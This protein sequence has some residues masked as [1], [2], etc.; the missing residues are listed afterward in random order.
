MPRHSQVTPALHSAGAT[1]LHRSPFDDLEVPVSMEP[2]SAELRERWV[3][4]F[5]MSIRSNI[6][7]TEH[8]LLP[9]FREINPLLI[10]TLL[11]NFN[12]RP[13]ITGAFFVALCRVGEF[14]DLIGRLL[15]RS[16]VCFA[17]RGYCLA[18]ARLNT[19][20]TVDFLREYLRYYLTRK[21]LWFDQA[22]AMSAM[23]YLDAAN[24]TDHASAFDAPW[25]DFV[26]DKPNWNLARSYTNFKNAIQAIDTLYSRCSSA[27]D[28]RDH[29][30]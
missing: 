21:E 6:A 23:Q 13:R 24:G 2:L 12:W 15:L 10:A 9:L 16:D 1:V 8:D 5:Y 20:R 27:S 11:S 25:A 18:L 30:E 26:S 19:P 4:P 22:D 17:G 29:P 14:E 3:K 7:A 28:G